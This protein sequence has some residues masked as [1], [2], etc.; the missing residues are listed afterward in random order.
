M[1]RCGKI[2]PGSSH[3]L[4]GVSEEYP[5]VAVVGLNNKDHIYSTLEER[6]GNKESIRASIAGNIYNSVNS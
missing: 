5:V 1:V 4:Y 2:K 6:D 3:V